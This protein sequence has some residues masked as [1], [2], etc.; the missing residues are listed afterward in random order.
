MAVY[1][2]NFSTDELRIGPLQ[3]GQ[4]IVV[5]FHFQAHLTRGQYHL[6]CHVFDTRTQKYTD[7]LVPTGILTVDETRTHSGI[8]DLQVAPVI[9]EPAAALVAREAALL[10]AR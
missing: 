8:A 3:A 6:G 4:E 1:D 7:R 5:D 2:A 9:V 10:H